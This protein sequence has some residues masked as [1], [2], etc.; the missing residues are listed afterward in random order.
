MKRILAL[1]L[2]L[3]LVPAALSEATPEPT[4]DPVLTETIHNVV[5]LLFAAAIG[6]DAETETEARKD[7]TEEEILVRNAANLEYRQKTLPWLTEALRIEEEIPEP[8]PSP[9]PSLTPEPSPEVS[10]EPVWTIEDSFAAFQENVLGTEYLNLLTTLGA[11]DMEAAMQLTKEY[12]ALWLE[13][14]DHEFLRNINADYAF[15]IFAPGT[16]ID[17]PVVHGEDNSKYLN[18]LF[19]GAKNS[20]GT[21]FVDYRNLPEFQDPNTLIYG[22]HMRNDSMFGALTDYAEQSFFDAHPYFL[23]I[24]EDEILLGEIFAGYTTSDKDHCYDIA[25]SDE[26]DM[27][28]FLDE[29]LRKSDFI[30]GVLPETT[31][32]LVTLSTCAYAF[33][34]ARYIAIA[35]LLPVWQRLLSA[36]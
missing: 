7:L 14:I 1:I 28:I 13:E 25:I 3:M 31:D 10:P 6:T 21:L 27:R 11:T 5:N 32:R 30:S 20:A 33:E 4:R 34:N 8:T 35:R 12:F 24:A 23:L 18:R 17:Y 2:A 16:Q 26:D 9:S 36:Q 15:W 22:H 19:N 29:A